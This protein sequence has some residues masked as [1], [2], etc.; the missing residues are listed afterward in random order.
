MKIKSMQELFEHELEDLLDAEKQLTE[1]LPKMVTAANSD[2]LKT[3]F[4][5]HCLICLSSST[6]I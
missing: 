6:S 1:A 2:A 5:D 4:K 3:A